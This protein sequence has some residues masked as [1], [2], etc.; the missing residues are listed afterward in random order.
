MYEASGG[1]AE[2][3]RTSSRLSKEKLGALVCPE[4]IFRMGTAVGYLPQ[5][6]HH[7]FWRAIFDTHGQWNHLRVVALWADM[8]VWV[9]ILSGKVMVDMLA[10]TP[11]EGEVRRPV[12][13]VC[14]RGANHMVSGRSRDTLY[15][16]SNCSDLRISQ[17]HY[18]E[19]E[20]FLRLV[21]EYV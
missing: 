17:Y 7:A 15:T 20:E 16:V 21:A 4:N 2:Y 11:S 14:L 1:D 5:V 9:C 13:M 3:L 8:S 19:P 18:E 6:Y 10:S 12:E